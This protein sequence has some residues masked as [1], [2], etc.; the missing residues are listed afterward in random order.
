MTDANERLRRWRMVLGGDNADGIGIA[1]AEADRGMDSALAMLY[2]SS[3]EKNVGRGPSAPYVAR[4]LGDIR[5][6]FPKSLVQVMQKDAIKRLGLERLLLEPEMLETVVPDVHLVGS[7]LSLSSA[8]S[9][10]ARDAARQVVRQLVD[11]LMRRLEQPMQHA[12]RGA[13]N[14][15]SRTRRPRFRDIDWN[16][17]IRANLQHYQAEYHTIVPHTRIGYGRKESR[18]RE[19]ILCLDQSGSMMSSVVYAGIFGCV[20]ASLPTLKTHVVA[21]DTAVVDLTEQSSDPVDLL[22]ATR[23]G[24][25]NDT[26]R[27]LT[28]CRGLIRQPSE[29]TFVLI[30]DLYEGEPSAEMLKQIA[31][32]QASGVQMIVLTTLSDEGSPSFDREN[33]AALAELGIPCFACTPDLFPDLMATALTHG[34]LRQWAAAQAPAE[35]A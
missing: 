28:Y 26:C 9:H 1:L 20:L 11:E 19:V 18:L 24:G 34:D 14:R 15:A 29:T 22:F 12:I 2:Q 35:S 27:A 21:Y 13:L 23:L 5:T 33:A 4:W 30:T 31:N 7:L 17:T 8:M 10:R 6:Y 3:D 32:L 25:G 16:R